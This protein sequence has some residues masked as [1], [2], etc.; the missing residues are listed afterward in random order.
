VLRLPILLRSGHQP[1]VTPIGVERQRTT[2]DDAVD[3]TLRP[4]RDPK[5]PTAVALTG[6]LSVD[7]VAPLV[8][9]EQRVRRP[10]ATRDEDL[11]LRAGSCSAGSNRERR[12]R[13]MVRS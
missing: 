4:G 1:P 6:G 10:P 13:P 2:L 12:A 9:Q 3:A 7:V 11:E 5:C 8:R